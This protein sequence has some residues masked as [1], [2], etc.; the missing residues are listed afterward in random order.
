[1]LRVFIISLLAVL[2]GG[3]CGDCNN[4]PQ[5]S[6]PNVSSVA[7][8]KLGQKYFASF[9]YAGKSMTL[10][11]WDNASVQ[12]QEKISVNNVGFVGGSPLYLDLNNNIPKSIFIYDYYTKKLTEINI[13]TLNVTERQFPNNYSI[14]SADEF[15]VYEG[16][17][18]RLHTLSTNIISNL[19]SLPSLAAISTGLG[20][21][22]DVTKYQMLC[23]PKTIFRIWDRKTHA[24]TI[25]RDVRYANNNS[26]SSINNLNDVYDVFVSVNPNGSY[27]YQ[28]LFQDTQYHGS[29]YFEEW[30]GSD[31]LLTY[32]PEYANNNTSKGACTADIDKQ[33]NLH[34]FCG[35]NEN[36]TVFTYEFYSKN[37]PTVPL[38]TQVLP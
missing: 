12:W 6:P 13:S 22:I 27:G 16:N 31:D 36:R 9:G 33:G 20:L 15:V 30:S 25:G 4:P 21:N 19:H 17:N 5:V 18:V 24:C 32:Y 28:L 38:Y 29:R 8:D 37:N 34:D 14:V 23:T 10:Y 7:E 26:P 1:M 2:F 35:T 3:C 11:M